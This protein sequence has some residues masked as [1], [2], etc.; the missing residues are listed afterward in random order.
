[1]RRGSLGIA[2]LTLA[3][4]LSVLAAT[5]ARTE[6]SPTGGRPD[7]V[8]EGTLF[9]R[10]AQQEALVPAPVL[11]TDVRMVVTGIVARAKVVQGFSNPSGEWAEGIY[12]FPLP[13]DAAVDHLRMTVGDRVIEGVVQERAAAK[14]RYEQARHDGRRASLVEQERP[15]IFTTSVANIPPGASIT[16]ELEYQQAI[17][18]DGGQFRLRFPMV[19]GPRYVPGTPVPRAPA[20]TG[21]VPDTDQLPDASRIT[22][23]VAHRREGP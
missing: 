7:R 2:G 21:S 6:G 13:E 8:T 19:V 14:A 10:T 18:Y 16:V 3:V 15:N 5:A 22:P 17:R 23:P 1:M 4:V 12:V 11:E 9:W 20:G